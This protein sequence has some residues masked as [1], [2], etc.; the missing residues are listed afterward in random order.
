MWL[1]IRDG[2]AKE[3]RGHWRWC[4]SVSRGRSVSRGN[5]RTTGTRP[6]DPAAANRVFPTRKTTQTDRKH[7]V[8]DCWC[9][10]WDSNPHVFKGRRILSPLRLP[11]RHSGIAVQRVKRY[12][13][14]PVQ[15]SA[16][17]AQEP[18]R[19]RTKKF[20]RPSKKERRRNWLRGFDLNKQPSGYEPDE[21]PGCSTPQ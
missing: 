13:I 10:R 12:H 2:P 1:E 15:A 3:P 18:V 9:Q 16:P 17:R 8:A 19:C 7:T 5:K 4:H 11:F 14:P 21:L 20:R 6:A